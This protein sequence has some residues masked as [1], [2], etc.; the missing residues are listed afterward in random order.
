LLRIGLP[1][2]IDSIA[3]NLTNDFVFAGAFDGTI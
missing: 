1:Q 3:C 2:T